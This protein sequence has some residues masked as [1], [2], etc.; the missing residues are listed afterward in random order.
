MTLRPI[1]PQRFARGERTRPR[2]RPVSAAHKRSRG[3]LIVLAGLSVLFCTSCVSTP[4]DQVTENSESRFQQEQSLPPTSKTRVP[5][6][7]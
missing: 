7:P 5:Y 6:V 1:D 3:G 2:L 4:P